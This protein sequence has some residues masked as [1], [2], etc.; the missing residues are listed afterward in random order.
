MDMNVETITVNGKTYYSQAPQAQQF[1]GDT[2][3]VILQRG[4]VMIGKLEKNGSECKLH[5]ASVIRNWGTTKGL[6]ELATE[7]KKKDTKL[8]KC[9]GV[10]EFD[11]LTVVATIA[12]NEALWKNEL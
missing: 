5:N 9:G 7:G 11:Y 4:W 3:I 1:V 2:K 6:G 12:V 10:V 8:D